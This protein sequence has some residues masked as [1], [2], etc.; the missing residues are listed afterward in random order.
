MNSGLAPAW[1]ISQRPYGNSG[2][3][4]E[5]FTANQGRLS[6]VAR[7]VHRKTAG[8][9]PAQ[10]LQVFYPL[11][12]EVAGRSELKTVTRVESAGVALRPAGNAA[13]CGMY[14]NE[15]V[16]RLLPR[17][18]PHPT[19]FAKYGETLAHLTAGELEPA[20]RRFEILLL[21]ELGYTINWRADARGDRIDPGCHYEFITDQGFVPRA[22]A[23]S[24]TASGQ[25]LLEIA[26]WV[27]AGAEPLS[28]ESL[29]W[30]RQW[31]RQAM[32]PLLGDRPLQ[33]REMAWS[34]QQ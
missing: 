5:F 33:T 3:L 29:R 20:L 27:D 2:R 4:V 21:S 6:A 25:L 16:L 12:I 7:G 31:T 30:A 23:G 24:A 19:L 18:D 11:L 9:Q 17:F 8:G 13:L 28:A 1:V 26:R 14:L 15:L 34:V 32:A 10:L 22:Q